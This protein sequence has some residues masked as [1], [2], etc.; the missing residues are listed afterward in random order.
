[1]I[2]FFNENYRL[3]G[4]LD[5]ACLSLP[6]RH[7]SEVLQSD[8]TKTK[9]TQMILAK[10]IKN[11][12]P[13]DDVILLQCLTVL[14]KSLK[15]TRL[16]NSRIFQRDFAQITSSPE[17]KLSMLVVTTRHSSSFDGIKMIF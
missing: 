4:V 13:N 16:T 14:I 12:L 17:I 9:E 11:A 2:Y 1:M 5:W 7:L 10:N 3:P 6:L 8:S 15:P